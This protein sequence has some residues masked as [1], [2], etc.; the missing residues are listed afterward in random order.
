MQALMNLG[1][2]ALEAEIYSSLLQKSP[3]TGYSIAKDLGKP[4][5]NVYKALETLEAKEA[6]E[7]E[8]GRTRMCRPVS[9]AELLDMLE[10]RFH[11]HRNQAAEGLQRLPGPMR[12]ARIYHLRD[13]EQ[14]AG[15]FRQLLSSAKSIVLIDA[16]W[17]SLL[18]LMQDLE[19]AA[20]RDVIVALKVYTKVDISGADVILHPKHEEI[21]TRWP[22]QWI[23]T[24]VDGCQI[25]LAVLSADGSRVVQAIWSSSPFLSWILHSSL[26]HELAW[27]ATL[28]KLEAGESIDPAKTMEK[29]TRRYCAPQVEGY[30]RLL[31]QLGLVDET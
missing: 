29:L 28:R 24:V 9:V 25:L 13:T 22:A 17:N 14:V 8:S 30:R 1:L 26:H 2:T 19:D 4:A 7:L 18:S 31:D 21:R 23:I 5:S 11:Q 6:I 20:L 3:A 10:R 12:D 27:S 15:K 16:H